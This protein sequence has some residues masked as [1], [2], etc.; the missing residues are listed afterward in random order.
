MKKSSKKSREEKPNLKTCRF[1]GGIV[2]PDAPNCVHC[3]SPSPFREPEKPK[4]EFDEHILIAKILWPILGIAC[5]V[6]FL[7]VLIFPGCRN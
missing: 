7:G 4:T 5:F 3:G 6:M 1:C 2:A